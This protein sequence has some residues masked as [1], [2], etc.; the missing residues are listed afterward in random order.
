[1]VELSVHTL[2]LNYTVK[3]PALVYNDM[4]RA[5][6]EAYTTMAKDVVKTLD[7]MYI[8]SRLRK[9]MVDYLLA[10]I[11]RETTDKYEIMY[12]LG[13]GFTDDSSEL[14]LILEAEAYPKSRVKTARKDSTVRMLIRRLELARV[15]LE[16]RMVGTMADIN[17]DYLRGMEKHLCISTIY[18]SS[19]MGKIVDKVKEKVSNEHWREILL[20][21]YVISDETRGALLA[22]HIHEN[23]GM[24]V[25]VTREYDPLTGLPLDIIIARKGDITVKI[26]AR[27]MASTWH[28]RV[29]GEKLEH[30]WDKVS[31][32]ASEIVNT[33]DS[34]VE[35]AVEE[36]ISKAEDA[37]RYT[38][39]RLREMV[40]ERRGKG[41]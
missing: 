33:P 14:Q 27:T 40:E 30:Y 11:F 25:A 4:H 8:V 31:A 24:D 13:V 20:G 16:N 12:Y 32:L 34:W 21:W 38:S 1:M 3:T 19:F 37:Y 26:S 39:M 28:V 36:I 22:K 23:V 10:N 35:D 6:L 17:K 15:S 7:D 18:L 29:G 9:S 5:L 41:E 2:S